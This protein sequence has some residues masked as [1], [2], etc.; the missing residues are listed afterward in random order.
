MKFLFPIE[1]S[2]GCD[3]KHKDR[4]GA[5][6]CTISNICDIGEGHCNSDNECKGNLVCGTENCKSIFGHSPSDFNCC[7]EGKTD[8]I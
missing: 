2:S 8:I 3:G 6:C 1:S 5:N 4:D 7:K